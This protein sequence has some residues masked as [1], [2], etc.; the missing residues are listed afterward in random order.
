[1][2]IAATRHQVAILLAIQYMSVAVPVLAASGVPAAIS[3][4]SL[5]AVFACSLMPGGLV[6]G[7][8]HASAI[9]ARLRLQQQAAAF[10]ARAARCF[11]C[12]HGH[13][14]PETGATMACDR[15]FVERVVQDRF[16]GGL[17]QFSQIVREALPAHVDALLGPALFPMPIWRFAIVYMPFVWLGVDIAL[18]SPDA[19]V[20]RSNALEFGFGFGFLLTGVGLNGLLLT[21]VAARTDLLASAT[22]R[23][24]FLALGSATGAVAFVLGWGKWD[25]FFNVPSSAPPRRAGETAAVCTAAAALPVLLYAGASV[26]GRARTAAGPRQ[27]AQPHEA[28]RSIALL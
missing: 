5:D 19:G 26:G 24:L 14:S 8:A 3:A 21:A 22:R 2:P 9:V 7:Y 6:F 1:M 28:T 15:E 4:T 17:A 18:C 27:P 13:T 20:R 16:D 25:A 11:C 10:D 23:R 12:D